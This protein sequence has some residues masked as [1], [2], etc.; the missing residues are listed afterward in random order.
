MN[1][2]LSLGMHQ[3]WN[4]RL[5][6]AVKG[7]HHLLDLCAGTGE[8]AFHFL[9][10]NQQSLAT[11]LDFCPE[12][13]QVAQEKGAHYNP[14]FVIQE[15]DAQKLP[16]DD[17]AFDAATIAYGIRNVKE[18]M[19]CFQE[20]YRILQVGGCFAILELTRPSSLFLRYGHALYLKTMLPILGAAIAKNKGAYA[21]LG[22]SIQH[23]LSPEDLMGSLGKVGF[24]NIKKTPLL[25]GISTLITCV[26]C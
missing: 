16:F 4:R 1:A 15:G 26:K 2:L 13:L 17:A 9:Q 20:V 18:P 24:S 23:F 22:K 7:S 25:G 5:A 8:I 11:L 19:R 12:M 10:E 3:K 6:H 21:Y 14:R